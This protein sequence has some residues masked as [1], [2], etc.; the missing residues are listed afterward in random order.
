[1][2]GV[3]RRAAAAAVALSASM[4]WSVSARRA[5]VVVAVSMATLKGCRLVAGRCELAERA[6]NAVLG[7]WLASDRAPSP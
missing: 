6:W 2:Y 7:C 5:A 3:G 1:M 4:Y